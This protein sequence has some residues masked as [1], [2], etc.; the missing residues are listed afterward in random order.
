VLVEALVGWKV[1]LTGMR[2]VALLDSPTAKMWVDYEVDTM[3][4][5]LVLL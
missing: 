2:L 1:V 4:C 3:A 5:Q